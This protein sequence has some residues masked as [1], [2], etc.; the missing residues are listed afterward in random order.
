M[1]ILL[2]GHSC[3]PDQGTELSFTWNWAWQLSR[4]HQVWIV[5]Y[6]SHREATEKFLQEHPNPN[7]QMLW[8]RPPPQL[9]FWTPGRGPIRFKFHYLLWQ[10]L[11]LRLAARLH[12]D[13]V[14]D[15]VH[16]VSLGTVSA[17]PA[18]WKLPIPLVWGPVGGGHVPPAAFRRYFG[19]GWMAQILRTLRIKL[20]PFFP[21]V[22]HA[23]QRS[24]AVLATNADTTKL[25]KAAGAREVMYLIDSGV[26]SNFEL[27]APVTRRDSKIFD[28][29]WVGTFLRS[30]GLAL[31]LEALAQVRDLPIRLLIAGDGPAKNH[32][33]ILARRLELEDRAQFLGRVN[34]REMPGLYQRAN[35]F[36]FTSLKDSFGTQVIE[37]MSQSLPILTLDHQGAG[38]FVPSSAG[39]KV[40]V[41]TPEETVAALAQAIRRLVESPELCRKMSEAAWKYAQEHTWDKRADQMNRLYLDV[42]SAYRQASLPISVSRT[43]TLG[44]GQVEVDGIDKRTDDTEQRAVG[45]NSVSIV[46]IGTES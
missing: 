20:L 15:L 3:S 10:H 44:G 36:I 42:A 46:D 2:V 11:A 8:V 45:T 25:L 9:D 32:W 40:A 7:L 41:T 31:A 35:A 26:P 30:K 39:I 34:W 17:P 21:P 38:D 29:L 16:H 14:F 6:P 12:R 18:L 22:R 37:A 23:A 27:P 4:Y 5:A 24:A 33:M 43:K 28:L 19:P 13:I 1:R